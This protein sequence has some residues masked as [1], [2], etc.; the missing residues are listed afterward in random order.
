MEPKRPFS[1]LD[2]AATPQPVKEY[3]EYLEQA[4]ATLV[5]KLEQHEKRI[6]QLETRTKKNSRNSSKPPSSDNPFKKPKK[7]SKKNKR[8]RGGQKGHK[9]HQQQ[10]LE[11]TETKI[12]LP[13]ICDCG[14]YDFDP[15]TLE[16]YYTHQHIELPEIQMDIIH[17]MLHKG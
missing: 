7:K 10:M 16:P 5:A 15:K 4:I 17:F 1:D 14:R 11:P 13:T 8:K 12:I 3:I 9:G 2:W 6:E